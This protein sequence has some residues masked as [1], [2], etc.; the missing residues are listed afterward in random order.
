M[1]V[2]TPVCWGPNETSLKDVHGM[3]QSWKMQVQKKCHR[4][5]FN[6]LFEY[7]ETKDSMIIYSF[8]QV[9]KKEEKI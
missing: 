4:E 9:E 7:M 8:S 2:E 3:G 1:E 5:F 6:Y